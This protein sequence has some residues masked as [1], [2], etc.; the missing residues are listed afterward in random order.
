MRRRPSSPS[1]AGLLVRGATLSY[2]GIMV[3]LPLAALGTGVSSNLP[4]FAGVQALT[5]AN[6]LSFNGTRSSHNIFSRNKE[7]ISRR[8]ARGIIT[9]PGNH[10]RMK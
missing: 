1:P 8:S 5:S 4:S 9:V 2:L 3:V 6:G 10:H 7:T